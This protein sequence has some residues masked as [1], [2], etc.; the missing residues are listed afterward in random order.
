MLCVV[1]GLPSKLLPLVLV[2]CFGLSWTCSVEL[3]MLSQYQNQVTMC[4][5]SHPHHHMSCSP[6]TMCLPLACGEQAMPTSH[7]RVDQGEGRGRRSCHTRCWGHPSHTCNMRAPLYRLLLHADQRL[8]LCCPASIAS[9][10]ALPQLLC[11]QVVH[12][13]LHCT[14]VTV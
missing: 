12:A 1:E 5:S 14:H 10:R 11:R 8:W 7:G 6:P 3:R 9:N 4:C 2:L 13:G